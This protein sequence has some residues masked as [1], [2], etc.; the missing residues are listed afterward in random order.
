MAAPIP[1][2]RLAP[3]GRSVIFTFTPGTPETGLWCDECLLPSRIRLPVCTI[4]SSG[5]RVLTVVETCPGCV[6]ES[7]T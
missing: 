1:G 4:D 6:E 2:G 5:V 7:R 3:D